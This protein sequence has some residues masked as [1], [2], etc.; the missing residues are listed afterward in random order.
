MVWAA[1]SEMANIGEII[2]KLDTTKPTMEMMVKVIRLKR[3]MAED[4]AKVL[5]E[6]LNG[7]QGGGRSK[8]SEAVIVNFEEQREDG[9]SE[10][11]KLVRQDIT[12]KPD[13]RTN[14][15]MVMA[16][17]ESMAMLESLIQTFDKIPPQTAEIRLFPLVNADAEEVV[18]RLEKIYEERRRRRGRGRTAVD[19]RRD[20]RCGRR[21]D[22]GRH[23]RRG[24][25]AARRCASLPTDGRTPVIAAGHGVGPADG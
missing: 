11:R 14:A 23:R 25:A 12:I 20:R 9:T 10:L 16:P 7:D 19:L 5:D 15:L 22:H 21:G 13:P 17:M 6:T 3:A 24:R 18:E 4:F 2:E 8:D 1:L